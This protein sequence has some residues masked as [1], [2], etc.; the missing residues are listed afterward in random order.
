MTRYPP[1]FPG[2]ATCASEPSPTDYMSPKGSLA[3]ARII[4]DAW[5]K[6]GVLDVPVRIEEVNRTRQD[7]ERLKSP[8]SLHCVRV[9][10]P[11]GLPA[12]RG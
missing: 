9:D 7:G 1:W 8:M 6:R 5:A 12:G 2:P 4:R 10:L 11:G 3:L